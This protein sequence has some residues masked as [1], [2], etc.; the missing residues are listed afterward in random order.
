MNL[1]ETEPEPAA[2]DQRGVQSLGR[3]F[4]RIRYS[5]LARLA[6]LIFSVD[7]NKMREPLRLPSEVEAEVT[8][9][10]ARGVR[11]GVPPGSFLQNALIDMKS[12]LR[13]I[14][15][16]AVFNVVILARDSSTTAAPSIQFIEVEKDVELEVVDWGGTGRALIFVAGLGA[17]AHDFAQFAPK[18]TDSYRVY[19]ITRRGFG[20][21]SVPS[22]GYSADR[23]GDDVIAVMDALQLERPILVGH[24]LGGQE[25]SSI[26]SRHPN[27][28]TALIYLEAGYHYAFY[29][30]SRGN[31]MI[32]ANELRRQLKCLLPGA[33]PSSRSGWKQLYADLIKTMRQL[34]LNLDRE[35]A[36]LDAM[37]EPPPPSANRPAVPAHVGKI[38]GGMQRYTEIPVPVLAIFGV[39]LQSAN[40]ALSPENRERMEYIT[41]QV[42]AF[43][44]GV[45]SAR[46]V[47]LLNGKHTIYKSKEADVLREMR[48]FIES[49]AGR[50]T[51]K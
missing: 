13:L 35:L 3:G 22:S 19:G 18:L 46:V 25:L 16:L 14:V 48:S 4:Y 34:E 42:D 50:A 2:S 21:S 6:W 15:G 49:L 24:S 39:P 43:E 7:Q 1:N 28:V 30:A 32:D 40:D 38:L 17:T 9:M 11:R 5:V 8:Q 45:P 41:R 44:K 37:P 33:S 29:D 12:C 47:R 51:G 36:K 20:K 27:K 31:M 10:S 26:G 23:L